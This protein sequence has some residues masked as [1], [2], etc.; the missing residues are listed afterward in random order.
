MQQYISI[1][2]TQGTTSLLQLETPILLHMALC[3]SQAQAE[4][5][6][7][8]QFPLRCEGTDSV[9]TFLALKHCLQSLFPYVR[10]F[11]C[12]PAQRTATRASLPTHIHYLDLPSIK[13]PLWTEL[14]AH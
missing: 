11:A 8:K 10:E 14:S 4:A 1:N 7:Q 2:H 6:T 3:S 9:V 12:H 13:L 5:L